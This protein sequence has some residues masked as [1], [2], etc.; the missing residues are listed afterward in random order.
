MSIRMMALTNCEIWLPLF[1]SITRGTAAKVPQVPGATG[2]NPL[3]KPVAR[4]TVRSFLR[5][6]FT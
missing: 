1:T 2:R 6:A 5:V 4:K 3:K